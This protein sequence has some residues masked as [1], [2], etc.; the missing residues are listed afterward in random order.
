MSCMTDC[1]LASGFIGA[2]IYVM[3]KDKSKKNELYKKL[4][5][6][7][8]KKYDSIRKERM[9]I[10]IKASLA[11][12]FL[13]ITFSKFG[14]NLFPGKSF[15][16]SCINTLIFFAVQYL[17]YM[18]HPKSDWMLNHVENNEEAKLWLK[19]YKYMQRRWHTGMVLGIVGYFFLNMVV[20]S[21]SEIPVI[22]IFTRL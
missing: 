13:S 8:K 3:L 2:S 19:K 14:K 21:K 17:V 20:F 10:W 15:D 1:I 4:S 5:D 9:M 16:K 12:I 7:K 11:G 18:L 6:E 22:K